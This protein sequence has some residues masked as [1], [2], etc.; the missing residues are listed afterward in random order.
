L[1][2]ESSGQHIDARNLAT[3]QEIAPHV[4]NSHF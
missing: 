3:A 2:R 4:C 1:V